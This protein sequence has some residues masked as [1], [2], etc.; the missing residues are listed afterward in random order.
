M[1]DN[2]K[3][4]WSAGGVRWVAVGIPP[5]DFGRSLMALRWDAVGMPPGDYSAIVAD[6]VLIDHCVGCSSIPLRDE[7]SNF[8]VS[9]SLL[10]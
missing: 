9:G 1:Y 2:M 6:V 10:R 3:N 5:G 7:C 8:S 4:W